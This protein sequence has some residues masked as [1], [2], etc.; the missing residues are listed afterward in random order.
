MKP[1][2]LLDLIVRA[3]KTLVLGAPDYR[4][5]R[6]WKLD[7]GA[8]YSFPRV[9]AAMDRFV[10]QSKRRTA[11]S[12]PNKACRATVHARLVRVM[13][14]FGES[15]RPIV[16]SRGIL[17]LASISFGR[18]S[19]WLRNNAAMRPESGIEVLR[20]TDFAEMTAASRWGMHAAF[21]DP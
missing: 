2:Q 7:L 15:R 13:D 9:S 4:D 3:W 10:A 14:H 18:H 8:Q 16:A 11:M 5:P 20:V 12:A 6:P 17:Q 21:D 1:A 19:A